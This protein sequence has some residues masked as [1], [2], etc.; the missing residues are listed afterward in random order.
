MTLS[1]C[2]EKIKVWCK[3]KVDS[4]RI[5][6]PFNEDEEQYLSLEISS[7]D[8]VRYCKRGVILIPMC[9]AISVL[10]Y[11]L[12]SFLMEYSYVLSIINGLMY[13]FS[14]SAVVWL[15]FMFINN[16]FLWALAIS[17]YL[18]SLQF[19]NMALFKLDWL[20]WLLNSIFIL[21][22]IIALSVVVYLY[23]TLINNKYNI[24]RLRKKCGEY[25]VK[26]L[27]Q[28][29]D[30]YYPYSKWWSKKDDKISIE[31]AKEAVKW[32]NI[33]AELG[34]EPVLNDWRYLVCKDLL[35]DKKI[36][37]DAKGGDTKAQ[38]Y[39]AQCYWDGI[40]VERS[41]DKASELYIKLALQG[42]APALDFLNEL[43][44]KNEWSYRV[45]IGEKI[46]EMKKCYAEEVEKG[47]IKA[48]IKLDELNQLP[49]Y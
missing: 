24:E 8:D 26:A 1:E 49:M 23:F 4:M 22:V 37:E 36:I 3:N 41:R 47:N 17:A 40:I 14:C 12:I 25:D 18:F 31:R 42:Y 28:M 30:L 35:G 11:F 21:Y 9:L 10:T 13:V 16:V 15:C 6:V 46:E 19:F 32:W 38:Y 45:F 43:S 33:A 44:S 5:E 29:G 2:F 48:Q 39:L 27:Y 34:Y 7:N 20:Y